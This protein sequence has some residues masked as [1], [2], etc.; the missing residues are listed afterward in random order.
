MPGFSKK[1]WRW[2]RNRAVMSSSGARFYTLGYLGRTLP[3]VAAILEERNAMLADI[4]LVPYSR[5]KA[6][7]KAV[8]ERTLG[9]RYVWVRALGNLNYKT[10]GPVALADYTMGRTAI[11]ALDT[12]VVL[13]CACRDYG[14]CHRAVVA[15][16]LRA[17]GFS[18][19]EIP[20]SHPE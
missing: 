17:E 7:I 16:A 4:R 19:E 9:P 13:M 12:P 20:L 10:G 8:L 2:F 3:E 15:E 5:N 6:F 11:L 18:V 1:R 14:R